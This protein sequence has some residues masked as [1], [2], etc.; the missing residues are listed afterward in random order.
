MDIYA[1]QVNCE[2]WPV[3][4]LCGWNA[5]LTDLE[6]MCVGGG[7]E[8]QVMSLETHGQ[9]DAGWL[10]ATLTTSLQKYK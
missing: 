1:G 2:R 8:V 6:P 5:G 9:P 3:D 7:G 10:A 4:C